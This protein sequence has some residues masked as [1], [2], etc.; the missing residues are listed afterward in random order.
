M[1]EN[2]VKFWLHRI[3]HEWDVSYKLLEA[4]Y[5][6]IGW[7]VLTGT[8]IIRS[9]SDRVD[10]ELF[11]AIM[12][13]NGLQS[14]RSRWSLWYFF[15]FNP[16]DVVLVPLYSGEFSLFR[17]VEKAV[18]IS[19]LH[20][21]NDFILTNGEHIGR[22]QNGLFFRESS[23]AEVDLGFAVHVE[24]IKEH[25]SRYEYA[26][27]RLTSRMKIRQ[28]N[29]DITDLADSINRVLGAD[30]PIN[31][32][33]AIIEELSDK[34]LN[35]ITEQLTPDKFE[36]LV[37][38]YFQKMGATKAF[39]PAKNESGKWDGA[40]ADIIAEYDPLKVVFYVQV[41]LHDNV[42][43]QWAVEQISKYK[44]QHEQSVGDYTII[45]WV[46]TSASE[47][48]SDAIAMAQDNNVRL[49]NGNEF[50]RM[51]IDAGITDIN[52]AFE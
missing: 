52:K 6:T 20:D 47:F 10:T 12:K 24:P 22:N 35:A 33:A 25:L 45:P 5:L 39:I 17:V 18:R 36:Y 48:S 44:D 11:E 32:Y 2:T 26:D 49:I 16:G 15:S 51:L 13:E 14:E 9:M 28:T 42:T 34:L 1:S 37:R 40:D 19:D 46:I 3:S 43:S 50:A 41:K 31:L 4:G 29:S 27:N 30:S 23:G 7:S 8:D 21:L 38:W